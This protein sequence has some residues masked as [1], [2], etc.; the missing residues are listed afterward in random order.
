M[1]STNHTAIMGHIQ[2]ASK[3]DEELGNSIEQIGNYVKKK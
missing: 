3:V 2:E 1:I